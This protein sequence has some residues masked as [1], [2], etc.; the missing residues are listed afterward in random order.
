MGLAIGSPLPGFVLKDQDGNDFDSK[1]L[2]ERVPLV[3]YFYPRDFTPG[4]TAEACA[5][6][7]RY[8]EFTQLGARVIGV[9][10]D[11]PERHKAFAQKHNLPFTLL[12]DPGGKLA[13]RFGVKSSLLGLLPGRET[14]IFDRDKKL[15]YTFRS[16]QAGP[17]ISRALLEI[18]KL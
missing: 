2:Q 10:S 15:V 18:K 16:M 17:H 11:S 6:R 3:L 13:T 14:F 1:I 9:S 8:A 4:C 12:S 5:F 7:D